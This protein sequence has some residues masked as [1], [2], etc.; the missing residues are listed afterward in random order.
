[1]RLFLD[2]NTILRSICSQE[3]LISPSQKRETVCPVHPYGLSFLKHHGPPPKM[4]TGEIE[5]S[6]FFVAFAKP[7][8]TAF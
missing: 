6:R 4:S 3:K 7:L 8:F 2:K 5:I 1:M